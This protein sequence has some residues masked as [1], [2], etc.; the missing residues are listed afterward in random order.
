[1]SRYIDE[2]GVSG[3]YRHFLRQGSVVT[4]HDLDGGRFIAWALVEESKPLEGL[5][6]TELSLVTSQLCFLCKNGLR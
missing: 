1:M 4:N 2:A 3:G 6:G 5:V